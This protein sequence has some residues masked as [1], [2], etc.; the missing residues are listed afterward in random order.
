MLSE[1]HLGWVGEGRRLWRASGVPCGTPLDEGL[2]R[3]WR[4]HYF[5]LRLSVFPVQFFHGVLRGFGHVASV[6]GV[7]GA[8][9]VFEGVVEA[10]FG[11]DFGQEGR[12]GAD[13]GQLGLVLFGED[14]L[15]VGVVAGGGDADPAIV[16]LAVLGQLGSR[17]PR[18]EMA[19]SRKDAGDSPPP[20]VA[21]R[22]DGEG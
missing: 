1:R 12:G 7:A 21:Q 15:E 2:L 13:W 22:G 10:A 3:H 20:D 16:V 19:K 5:R 6:Q 9:D 17:K 4:R 14:E 8:V 18:R 11:F